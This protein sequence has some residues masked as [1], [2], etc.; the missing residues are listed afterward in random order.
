MHIQM[1][2]GASIGAPDGVPPPIAFDSNPKPVSP[3]APEKEYFVIQ[4]M[5]SGDY[6]RLH[7]GGLALGGR[8]GPRI[9]I[10]HRGEALA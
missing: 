1:I 9:R 4:H 5:H 8:Q 2:I 3:N 6:C 7:A 10:L